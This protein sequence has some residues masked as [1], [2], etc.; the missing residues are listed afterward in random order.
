MQLMI[1]GQPGKVL[2]GLPIRLSLC[3]A[4]FGLCK[5]ILLKYLL[6]KYR[7]FVSYRIDVVYLFSEFEMELFLVF[8]RTIKWKHRELE[9]KVIFRY[10]QELLW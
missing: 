7:S 6:L 8:H 3:K 1:S 10:L 4:F 9:R 2:Q 5:R